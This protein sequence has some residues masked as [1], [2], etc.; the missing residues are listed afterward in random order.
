MLDVGDSEEVA[1]AVLPEGY[2][3]KED[4]RE[5]LERR[6]GE[7][8]SDDSEP[9]VNGTQPLFSREIAMNGVSGV[10]LAAFVTQAIA[11]EP[12]HVLHSG[13]LQT[14]WKNPQ[15]AQFTIDLYDHLTKS[16]GDQARY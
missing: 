6:I 2:D 3:E 4:W 5:N 12:V 16:L 13:V 9:H 7:L 14:L 8:D 10:G 1:A 11:G 15:L